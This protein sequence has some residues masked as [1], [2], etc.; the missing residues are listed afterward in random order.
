MTTIFEGAV[1]PSSIE[2]AGFE[3]DLSAVRITEV[4][5]NQ[6][7][8]ADYAGLTDGLPKYTGSACKGLAEGTNGWVLKEFTYDA[9]RQCTKILIAYGDWTSRSTASYS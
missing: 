7:F 1:K 6:Q 4:S 9:N 5:S 8:R 2:Q 3:G